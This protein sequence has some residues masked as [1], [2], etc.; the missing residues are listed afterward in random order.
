MKTSNNGINLIK[1]FEGV[2]L[3]AYKAVTTEKYY[4]IGYGH[5]GA[6][7]KAGMKIT[8]AQADEYLK[9]DLAKFEA[10]VNKYQVQYNFNQNQYDALVSF[11]YNVGNIDG[12]TKKGTRTIEQ[13]A[14]SFKLYNKSGGKVLQG[15]VNR[16]AKE[17]ALFE[18]AITTTATP[19]GNYYPKY[20]GASTQIDVVLQGAQVENKYRGSYKA[21]KPIADANGIKNYTGSVT[22]N[23]ALIKLAKSGL[24][25]RPV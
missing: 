5:Y 19:I 11:A 4:T 10:K 24:L 16:R 2:R 22:Q 1:S 14:N 17:K 13:I 21:R 25:K 3:T 9:A 12:L 7:V 18:S 6:D 20:T 8:Q 23:I 15:L